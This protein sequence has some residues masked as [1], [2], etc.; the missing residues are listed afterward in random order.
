MRDNGQNVYP[1]RDRVGTGFLFN[2]GSGSL[3]SLKRGRQ[4][5]ILKNS[6]IGTAAYI[7]L[8]GFMR[9]KS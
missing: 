2:T 8:G 5:L 4:K 1:V 7:K 3:L 6:A 9:R